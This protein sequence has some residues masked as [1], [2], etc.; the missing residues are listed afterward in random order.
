MQKYSVFS[1]KEKYNTGSNKEDY[2]AWKLHASYYSQIANI[3]RGNVSHY[4]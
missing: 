1:E 3:S 2:N 4:T